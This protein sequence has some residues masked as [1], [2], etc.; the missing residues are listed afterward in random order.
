MPNRCPPLFPSVVSLLILCLVACAF[1]QENESPKLRDFG[2]SVKRL[3][4]DP[5][6]RVAIA[7]PS[8]PKSY[9][10]DDIDVVRV[11]TNLVVCDVLVLDAHGQMV[12]GLTQNDFAI[13]ED[14]SPQQVGM[15]SMGDSATV[16]R[17]IVLIIDYSSSQFPFLSNS[18]EAAKTLVDKLPPRDR[19]AIVTD[20]VE[21]LLDF[22]SD[23]QK[24][25][26]ALDGLLARAALSLNGPPGQPRPKLGKSAQYSA[27]MATL[28][29]V[30]DAEDQRP[31]VIF[32]TD[33]DE[34]WLLRDPIVTPNVPPNLPKDLEKQTRKSIEA[35][36]KYVSEHLREFSLKDLYKSVEEARATIYTIV[37]GFRLVG[38]SRDDLLKQ[39]HLEWQQRTQAWSGGV[40]TKNAKQFLKAMEDRWKKSPD[41]AHRVEAEDERNVQ[42]A[43]ALVAT[44]TGGWTAFLESA[45]Q[46]DEI[47]SRIFDDINQR[48]IVGYYP[49]NKTH[50]GK[51]RKVS[52]SV[53]DHPEYVVMGRKAYYAPALGQ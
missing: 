3:K 31:I 18:I 39:F 30:F 11:E 5:E 38:L 26:G 46:A 43:L 35:N 28:K 49:R 36:I 16:P 51:R 9:K 44:L 8:A 23:K 6:R 12:K 34:A 52:V 20:D 17:S 40:P 48:Y 27:L 4:W 47:Y 1:A 15:F 29:E 22:T 13:T 10:T 24:L 32:Q 19:M 21:L 14:N 37:P 50:D 41:E 33:G 45:S 53:R 7:E 25:K 42:E 2:S